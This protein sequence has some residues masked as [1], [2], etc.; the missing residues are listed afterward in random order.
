MSSLIKK[1]PPELSLMVMDNL[2]LHV[3][4]TLASCD[5]ATLR[6]VKMYVTGRRNILLAKFFANPAKFLE[7]QRT[8]KIVIGNSA[9]LNLVLATNDPTAVISDNLDVYTSSHGCGPLVNFL[10]AEGLIASPWIESHRSSAIARKMSLL[11]P[12]KGLVINITEARQGSLMPLFKSHSTLA[13]NFVS[14]AGVFSAY[15]VMTAEHRA[16]LNPLM[17]HKKICPLACLLALAKYTARGFDIQS[18][19]YSQWTTHLCHLSTQCPLCLRS[20]TDRACM[21]FS[22]DEFP[23]RSGW[24]FLGSENSHAIIWCLGGSSCETGNDAVLPVAMFS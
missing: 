16:L 8:F 10:A 12:A 11:L 19:G 3:L 6:R 20:T 4:C 17:W 9:A 22:F 23:D 15:P 24:R 21:R 2:P 14:H 7:L 5:K 13:M 1:F 18:T